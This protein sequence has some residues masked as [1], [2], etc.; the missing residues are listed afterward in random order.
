METNSID[1]CA[2]HTL[3]DYGVAPDVTMMSVVEL[4]MQII[5]EMILDHLTQAEVSLVIATGRGRPE[6]LYGPR[7][8]LPEGDLIKEV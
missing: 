8:R 1:T 3:H 5:F 7:V 4:M 2:Q 6:G